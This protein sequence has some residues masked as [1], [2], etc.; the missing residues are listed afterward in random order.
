VGHRGERVGD[1]VVERLVGGD[2]RTERGH[3]P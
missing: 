1:L 2:E 3:G